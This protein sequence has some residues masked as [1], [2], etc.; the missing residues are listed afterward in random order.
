MNDL[1]CEDFGIDDN[2]INKT[3]FES[4]DIEKIV[5]DKINANK[6]GKEEGIYYTLS[7]NAILEVNKKKYDDLI[8]AFSNI[9]KEYL[10]YY[11]VKKEDPIFVVGL[12]NCNVT[13][14]SLGPKV[15]EM[16]NVTS[17]LFKLNINENNMQNVY[18]LSPGVMSQT[19]LE[20]ADIICNLV[21]NL[22][23]KLVIV[24]DALASK[25]LSR[26]NRTIQINNT[27]I[28]PGA[29][30]GNFRKK[31]SYDTLG[32][33]VI[34]VG[35]PTVVD[36]KSIFIDLLQNTSINLDDVIPFS[37][38]DETIKFMVTPKEIDE[39]ILDMSNI[40]SKGL[41]LAFHNL[42]I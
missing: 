36:V 6:I 33:P 12:G 9:I 26:I 39:N 28:S 14:D 32:C 37:V 25:S 29:G 20:T 3:K 31:F 34:A 24:I 23:P 41:N 40:I 7:S 35:V 27:S 4:V 10:N 38:E 16:I 21:S 15:I 22:N 8:N 17:H 30:I 19:G 42:E 2:I 5:L 1:I 11:K 13:P 18:A